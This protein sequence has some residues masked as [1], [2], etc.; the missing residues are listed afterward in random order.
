MNAMKTLADIQYVKGVKVL[1]RV[2]FNVPIK[3][4]VVVDDFRIRMALPTIQ[5]LISRGAKVIL[6]AHLESSDGSNASLQPV[7]H[8]LNTLGIK[9]TF[10]EN[11]RNARQEIEVMQE[12]D[13]ILLNNLRL[14]S[15]EKDN[16]PQFAKEL[17]SL[18]DIYVN[19]AFSVSHREH[20]S[21]VGVPRYIQGYVGLQM[22]REIIHLSRAFTPTHPF[23]FILGGA[24]FETKVP[25]IDKF[26]QTADIVYVAGALAND[27]FKAKGYEVGTSLLSKGSFDFDTF[28]NNKKLTIPV[29]VVNQDH[30]TMD[31]DKVSE[32]DKIM[33]AGMKSVQELGNI[34]SQAQ[35]ILWNGP[36]GL[37]EDG[38][39]G[40]TLEVAR[41]IAT[42]TQRGATSIIGGG[43][44]LAAVAS[45][46][47]SDKFTFVSTGGG[48]MLDFLATGTLPGIQAL[49]YS[50]KAE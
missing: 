21:V 13:V 7:A 2:D 22:E 34:I 12:G 15:G 43:D 29:D 17:A 26:L 10:V 47:L 31:A 45:L 11:M 35:F 30:Q 9:T 44:T 28:L 50:G 4:G 20:A 32:T 48:A 46:G 38:Y 37:Y 23:V 19:D 33:D 14:N 5:Y 42:A 49:E 40:A 18:A 27:F 41:M 36:F 6:I 25:L 24:K 3:N 8:I 39:Q 1:T 16:D